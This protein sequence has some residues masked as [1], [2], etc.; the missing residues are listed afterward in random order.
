MT[1]V[2]LVLISMVCWGFTIY[3]GREVLL[4][5]KSG[6]IRHT[7]SHKTFNRIKEPIKYWIVIF[8]FTGLVFLALYGW[9]LSLFQAIN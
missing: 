8:L 9:G 6:I 5:I 2:R 3:L 4:G 7:D 1:V